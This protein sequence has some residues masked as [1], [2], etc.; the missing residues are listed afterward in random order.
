M[1]NAQSIPLKKNQLI[2]KIGIVGLGKTGIAS[3]K[4]AIGNNIKIF[5][6]DDKIE[7]VP[8]EFSSFFMVYN[9][10]PWQELD[11][12]VFSPGVPTYL[13]TP[14]KAALLAKK[15]NVP[16]ISDVEL[17]IKLQK[18]SKWV[19]I[20]GTNGKSTTTALTAHILKCSGQSVAVGGNLG[21][22]MAALDSPGSDGIRV[23]E[24]SSYQLEITPSL[25][26][27]VS[28]ILN[29]SPD[30]LDRHGSM[31]K[32]AAAKAKAIKNVK[33]E[34]L[35]ILGTDPTLLKLLPSEYTCKMQQITKADIPLAT[36]Q[37][38]ALSGLHNSENAAVAASICRYFNISEKQINKS[39]LS[40]EG[41]PHRLQLVASCNLGKTQLHII[42]DSKATNDAAASKA[43][44]SFKHIFWCVG[45]LAKENKLS[46]CIAQSSQVERAYLYGSSKELFQSELL[47]SVPITLANDLED[48]TTR[49]FVDA[50]KLS[51]EN[52]VD[53]FVLLSPAAASFDTYENFEAR[54]KH[55]SDL[56]K[57]LC[58]QV[59]K[60]EQANAR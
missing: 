35:I 45:G 60:K 43:L 51:I 27:D 14:H 36:E 40:F 12:V 57:K 17:V 55:F 25:R 13:P 6:F 29:L 31:A 18:A 5:I 47:G 53:S 49:A 22:S 50:K 41:L 19:V 26:P 8:S 20:T 7:N 11:A 32:Y 30:H 4:L 33:S 24:L 34:G 52:G 16:I 10:W 38:F 15:F 23:V 3:I 56:A 28:A 2:Q 59:S 58:Q 54:G 42:N 9:Q 37:N 44:S 1:L 48:A 39:I 21:I 46:N